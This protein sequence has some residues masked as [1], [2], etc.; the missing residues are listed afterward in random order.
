MMINECTLT[1]DG[2]ACYFYSP[3]EPPEF[4]GQNILPLEEEEKE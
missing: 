3:I 1:S 2:Q 4:K